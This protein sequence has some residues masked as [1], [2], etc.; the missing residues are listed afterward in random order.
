MH[1]SVSS[2]V[3]CDYVWK[4]IVGGGN[5]SG[6]VLLLGLIFQVPSS[7]LKRL[8]LTFPFRLLM[9]RQTSHGAQFQ[10]HFFVV[11]LRSDRCHRL[12]LNHDFLPPYP[13][14]RRRRRR[15]SN[16]NKKRR[17]IVAATKDENDDD[18][19]TENEGD[20]RS[21]NSESG[22]NIRFSSR[23][24]ISKFERSGSDS[25]ESDNQKQ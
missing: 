23:N 3:I 16:K 11:F 22:K 24:D 1:K 4:I 21:R 17:V 12:D 14:R 18:D 13:Q 2:W 25:S 6:M 20:E 15:S 9:H 7:S 19:T 10:K 5:C 8:L